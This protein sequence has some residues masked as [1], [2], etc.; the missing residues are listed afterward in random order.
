MNSKYS[1]RAIGGLC[2]LSF[3]GLSFMAFGLFVFFYVGE[4]TSGLIIFG[5]LIFIWFGLLIL[6]VISLSYKSL[7]IDK[8]CILIKPM[9]SSKIK[10]LQFETLVYCDYLHN[11]YKFGVQKGIII[12]TTENTIEIINEKTYSNSLEII[13]YIKTHCL[14][15]KNIKEPSMSQ[16]DRLLFLSGL[17]IF[18][19]YIIFSLAK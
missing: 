9:F 4:F 2:S 6:R 17:L 7:V 12:K 5:S 19:L 18:I 8:S 13:D 3:I 11:S 1:R 16:F 10:I 14:I 15:D